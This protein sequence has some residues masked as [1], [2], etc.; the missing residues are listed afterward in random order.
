LR[1]HDK[2]DPHNIL[3]LFSE[4][5]A[6]F[7]LAKFNEAVLIFDSAL[8]VDPDNG[9]ILYEKGRALANLKRHDEAQKIFKKGF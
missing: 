2:N 3:L 6:L 7:R 5:N 8:S 1:K 9:E 4:G